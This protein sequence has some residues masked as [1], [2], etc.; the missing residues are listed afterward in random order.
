M[1]VFPLCPF[2]YNLCNSAM[3]TS[4][5]ES[6]CIAGLSYDVTLPAG[7]NATVNYNFM[8]KVHIRST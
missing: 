5:A 8:V 1:M 3:A 7:K 4:F 6:R 2:H